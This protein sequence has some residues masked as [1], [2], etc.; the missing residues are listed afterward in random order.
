VKSLIQAAARRAGYEIRRIETQPNGL[1]GPSLKRLAMHHPVQTVIDVGASDGRWSLMAQ[2]SFPDAAFL[3]FEAQEGPY[4][5]ALRGLA[6]SD[7]H[8]HAVLAAAGDHS[9]TIHFDAR[10]A[11]GGVASP[12]P[13]GPHDIVVPLTTVDA[14]VAR[15]GLTGPY[16]LKLDTHGYEVPIL[17]GASTVL[18]DAAMLVIE[19]Y[20]FQLTPTSLQFYEMCD[21]LAQRGFRVIDLVDP[22]W[23]PRDGAFWQMDVI[24]LRADQPEFQSSTYD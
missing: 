2:Q 14:E 18:A 3:L 7:S 15:L 20:N 11:D 10:L 5:D 1:M 22:M 9:G 24:Y 8:M 17:A 16:L 23:R 19:A 4:A 12:E 6:A 21:Y 13:T